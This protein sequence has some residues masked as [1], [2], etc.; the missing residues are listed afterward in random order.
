VTAEPSSAPPFRTETPVPGAADRSGSP[1]GLRVIE[2]QTAQG[3]LD[4][5]FRMLFGGIFG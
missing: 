5:L 2:K 4:S 1:T 3:P